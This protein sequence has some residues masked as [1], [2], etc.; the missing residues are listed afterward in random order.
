M[1]LTNMAQK[2]EAQIRDEEII[3]EK[4]VVSMCI[5]QALVE[6]DFETAYSYIMTRLA[7][8]AGPAQERT[9]HHDRMGGLFAELPPK[10][11]DDWSWRAALQAGSYHRS[12]QTVKPTHLGN[13]SGNP[14][15][16]H[17]EQRMEC[18][19]L[20]IRLAPKAALQA[21][22]NCMLSLRCPCLNHSNAD[23]VS[24]MRRRA[25]VPIQ[26]GG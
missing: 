2:T 9:P 3:A 5:D 20:A 19:S 7:Q 11:L 17:L 21:I 26:A 25:R 13:A 12:E 24:S 6:E 14:K 8:I 15:I 22:L 1:G 10:E 18:L 16:R 4:R 23:S